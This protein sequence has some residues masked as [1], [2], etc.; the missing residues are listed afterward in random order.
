MA[1]LNRSSPS[2][3][4]YQ[5]APA[6]R[7]LHGVERRNDGVVQTRRAERIEPVQRR[8]LRGP[9]GGSGCDDFHLRSNTDDHR[10]VGGPQFAKEH[11]GRGFG[12]SEQI[13]GHAEAAIERDGGSQRKL[14]FCKGRHLLWLAILANQEIVFRQSGDGLS[15][16]V[17]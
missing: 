10:L 2:E 9:V 15:S 11:P 1:L 4:R 7:I 6:F 13:L 17:G 16:R 3:S 14:A 12:D 8:V 5:R